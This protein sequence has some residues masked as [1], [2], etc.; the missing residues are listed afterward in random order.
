MKNDNNRPLSLLSVCRVSSHEQSEGY[1]L[2]MQDQ[3]NREWAERKGYTIVDTIRYIETAS[4]QKERQRFH[5]I[6]NGICHNCSIDGAVFHKVDRA[7]RNLTDL[8]MLERIETENAKRVFFS[9]QEFPQNAA[10]RLSIGV[11]GVVARWYTDNLREEVNKGLRGKVEA[12]E[13]PHRPPYGYLMGKNASGSKLPVPDP[14]KAENVRTIFELMALGNYSIDTLREELFQRGMYFSPSSHRWTRSHLAKLLRHPFY[15][16]KILWRGQEYEGKHDPIIDEHTWQQ[17][18]TVLDGRNN[19]KNTVLRQFT[20]GHGLIKCSQCGYSITAE[21]HKQRYIYYRC[22]QLRQREHLCKPAWVREPVI[23]SQ[24]ITMLEKLRLPKEVYDWAMAYLINVL[25]DDQADGQKEL[26]RLKKR[27]SE[28]RATVDS[29]LL[30]AA[31]ADD[32]LIESFMRL[33][34][35]KQQEITLLER[36]SEQ[37][38]KGKGEKSCEPARIFELSQN[39]VEHY[40]T[41][42]AAQKRQTIE[43]VFSNLQLDDVNLCAEYR[44]PFSILAENAHRPL[45]Y[46]RQD[47]NLRPSV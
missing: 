15:I 2:E 30:R 41:F 21:L 42:P 1:S 3:A 44:L 19:S 27:I 18:Q 35:K 24:I 10:G 23:E 13:Y 29:L 45:D 22:S 11:M 40:I 36:R 6:M 43:T 5:E 38:K 33:A 39:L 37:I 14:E 12:G 25:A 47:S 8:A 46:A 20:Y 9:S 7:C 17:V 16:G 34:K 31:Q 4:K 28:M 32:S 26:K